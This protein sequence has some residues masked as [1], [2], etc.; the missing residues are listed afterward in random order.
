ML[1]TERR[2]SSDEGSVEVR[3]EEV[4]ISDDVRAVRGVVRD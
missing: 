4:G 3:I 2:W 1:L